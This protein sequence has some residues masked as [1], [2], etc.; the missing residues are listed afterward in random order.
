MRGAMKRG[1]G[2]TL[3]ELLV[4]IAMVG[5]LVAILLPAVQAARETARRAS[6]K[7][8]LKQMGL[9]LLNY[10][11]SLGTFPSGYIRDKSANG[12]PPP[13]LPAPI[14]PPP[15]NGPTRRFDAPPPNLLIE[16]SKPGW[17]WASLMLAYLEQ[18]SLHDKIP[19]DSPVESPAAADTRTVRLSIY[20]CP[21][22]INTGVYTVLD[23]NNGPL[24]DTAT[25]SYVACFGSYG[26][27]NTHPDFGN[28][29]FQRNSGRRIADILD[30]TSQTI[31]IGERGC[32]F[33]QSP[34]AG[35]MTGGT[36]R[37]KAGAPVYSAVIEK[38][39]SMVLARIG[40]REL[41]SPYSEPYDFFS[42]HRNVVQ[43]V[44]ADGSVHA[45]SESVDIKVLHALATR[46]AN[47]PIDGSAY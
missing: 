13:I 32:I 18:Q 14:V 39:P 43:F 20:T 28:G 8:N 19:F 46:D 31:A 23:E 34:W 5:I 17:G 7:N 36:C 47:E 11:D 9:A 4:V 21:S 22:D 2:F 15:G 38:A 26:L 27:I 35:V 1:V 33:A 37:T 40:N 44:F 3:I 6:C 42:P 45:I 25:N 30:G 41:N 12:P 16:S 24:A 10:H 29:L